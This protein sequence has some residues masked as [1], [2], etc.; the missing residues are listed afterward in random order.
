VEPGSVG[1]RIKQGPP[2]L[3][4]IV[5]MIAAGDEPVTLLKVQALVDHYDVPT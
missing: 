3:E 5:A 1:R 2:L 4:A